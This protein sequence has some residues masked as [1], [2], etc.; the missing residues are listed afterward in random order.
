MVTWQWPNPTLILWAVFL[1]VSRFTHGTLQHT[2]MLLSVIA[3]GIWALLEIFWGA[4]PFR[5]VL[6]AV[7]LVF[8]ILSRVL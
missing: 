3:L 8:M 1:V 5:R 7:V 6:G 2:C 4:S